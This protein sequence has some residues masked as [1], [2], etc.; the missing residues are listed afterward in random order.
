MDGLLW[1]AHR[2]HFKGTASIVRGGRN[3]NIHTLYFLQINFFDV[4]IPCGIA[5]C[6]SGLLM[7]GR[8]PKCD[9]CQGCLGGGHQSEDA[10]DALD[11]SPLCISSTSITSLCILVG[12]LGEN[13][14]PSLVFT[15][16]LHRP[17]GLLTDKGQLSELDRNAQ[18]YTAHC[19]AW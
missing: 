4:C 13:F 12:N 1:K 2:G 3:E 16:L 15:H 14:N 7:S 6:I 18:H 9:A 19:T 8:D 5:L 10:P 11:S 17:P